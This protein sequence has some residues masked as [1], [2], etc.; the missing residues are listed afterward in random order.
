[1]QASIFHVFDVVLPPQTSYTS[2]TMMHCRAAMTSSKVY[3]KPSTS[4]ATVSLG[5]S[6]V[7]V[8]QAHHERKAIEFSSYHISSHITVTTKSSEH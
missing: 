7:S 8:R 1:M 5:I 2:S 3:T 6:A 4:E